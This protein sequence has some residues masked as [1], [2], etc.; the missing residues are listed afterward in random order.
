MPIPLVALVG[1]TNVGKSALFNA[2][3]KSEVTTENKLFATL[4]PTQRRFFLEHPKEVDYTNYYQHQTILI[5]TVGFIR[6]LPEELLNAFRATLEEIS[7]ANLLL[8]VLDASDENLA[9][10]HSAVKQQLTDAGLGEIPCLNVLNK[11][12]LIDSE[13]VQQLVNDFNAIPVSAI[14]GKGFVELRKLVADTLR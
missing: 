12:D 3:T 2:L 1:Y 8:H 11:I 10:S 14:K 5:D 4:D 13:L 9:Q 7:N 6:E